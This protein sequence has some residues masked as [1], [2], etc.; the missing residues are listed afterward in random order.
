MRVTEERQMAHKF[1]TKVG[2]TMTILRMKHITQIFLAV[3]ISI[4]HAGNKNLSSYNSIV[5]NP[6]ET[7]PLRLINSFKKGKAKNDSLDIN[8]KHYGFR[9]F[10]MDKFK[11]NWIKLRDIDSLVSLVKSKE[12]CVCYVNSL[13][14]FIP[15]DSAELGGYAVLV[16][17]SFQKKIPLNFGMG[18]CPK[19][20]DKKA[21]EIIEWWKN[22]KR[23]KKK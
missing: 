15:K 8:G 12:K 19:E 14:S 6:D 4:S 13:S 1:K 22:Y 23:I 11:S 17:E 16:I 18:C 21:D 5:L 7:T 3:L 10:I 9:S 2:R 20:D